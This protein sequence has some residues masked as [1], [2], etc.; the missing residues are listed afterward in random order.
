MKIVML[1]H[2]GVGKTTYMAS[3]Y[4][5]MQQRVEG[6]HLKTAKSQDH[7]RLLELAQMIRTGSYPPP[8]AQRDDYEFNLKYRGEDKLTFTWADY[9]G[10]ALIEKTKDSEQANLLI[11]DLKQADGIMMFCD[12]DAIAK[13]NQRAIQLGRMT[14]FVNRAVQDAEHPIALAIILTKADLISGFDS[15]LLMPFENLVDT[16]NASDWVLGSFIPISCGTLS[17]NVPMP[18]L[19]TL[20]AA[21]ILQAAMSAALI[22]KHYSQAQAWKA[23]S[24]GLDG[25]FRWVGD[26]WNGIPTDSQM[27]DSQMQ[28]A[29][30]QYHLYESIKPS[31]EALI[32][33]VQNLPQISKK[34]YISTYVQELSKIQPGIKVS[35][36][37]PNSSRPYLDP[38]DA[39]N[40]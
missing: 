40:H 12:C 26:K 2:T 27:A 1:G 28:K 13:G 35:L 19:F 29:I 11:Q 16:I 36:G 22:E 32:K 21:V 34:K 33:Y 18:L 37:S 10:G 39:F 25:L 30:E 7:S 17:A 3:L 9:R 8:T 31:A 15:A 20:H 6:F 4:E 23:K 38:F 24:Q 14:S 5:S